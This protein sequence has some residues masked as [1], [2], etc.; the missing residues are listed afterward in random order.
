[1]ES[2]SAYK[3]GFYMKVLHEI[4]RTQILLFGVDRDRVQ[5]LKKIV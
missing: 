2:S 1:M 4:N 5:H 3:S